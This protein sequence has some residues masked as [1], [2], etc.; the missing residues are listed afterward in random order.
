MRL[1]KFRFLVFTFAALILLML[2]ACSATDADDLTLD[3]ETLEASGP[4]GIY[5]AQPIANAQVG[6]VN[7]DLFVAVTLDEE[8]QGQEQ[9]QVTVY[10]CDGEDFS[11]WLSG[12]VDAQ[13]QALL[14]EEIGA[15]VALAIGDDGEVSGVVQTPDDNPQPFT[16]IA[17]TGDAG[18]YRAEETF[19]GVDHVGGWI[20]LNDG[21]QKGRACCTCP[22]GLCHPGCCHQ[23]PT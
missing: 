4:D 15:Q 1:V 18:L 14:G 5:R 8:G 9:Q 2:A 7:D 22:G 20:V 23:Q 6:E 10:L 12:E 3:L 11:Q 19:N 21:R 13:G 17:A 16:T